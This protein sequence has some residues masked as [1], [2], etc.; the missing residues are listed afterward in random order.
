MMSII[1][2]CPSQQLQYHQE[3]LK[4]HNSS[5]QTTC[6]HYNENIHHTTTLHTPVHTLQAGGMAVGKGFQPVTA[7]VGVV[8]MTAE[9]AG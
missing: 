2:T 3:I 1:H 5:I 8:D 9:L 7:S 4:P 6:S